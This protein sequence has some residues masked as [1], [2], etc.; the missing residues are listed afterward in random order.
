NAFRFVDKNTQ[1]TGTAAAQHL[2]IDDFQGLIGAYPF[3]D[4]PHSIYDGRPVCH[5]SFPPRSFSTAIR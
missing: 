5:V 4:F 2:D 1:N 3:R